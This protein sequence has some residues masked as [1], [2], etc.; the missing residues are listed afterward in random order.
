MAGIFPTCSL[1]QD[2]QTCST[3]LLF[4]WFWLL[5]YGCPFCFDW[6]NCEE[7]K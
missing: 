5:S 3:T 7:Y 6:C 4:C 1:K 2:S